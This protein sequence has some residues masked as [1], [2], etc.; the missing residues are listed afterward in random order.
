MSAIRLQLR[1]DIWIRRDIIKLLESM[2]ILYFRFIKVLVFPF[3][4][5]FVLLVKS[6]QK[7]SSGYL[8]ITYSYVTLQTLVDEVLVRCIDALWCN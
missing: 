1:N 4:F 3:I 7:V 8:E 2:L 5:H 6:N